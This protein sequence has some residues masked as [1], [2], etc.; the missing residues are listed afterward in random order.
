MFRSPYGLSQFIEKLLRNP[1]KELEPAKDA[2]LASYRA[3]KSG[4]TFTKVK[5]A[6]KAD[7]ALKRYFDLHE[8]EVESW[9]NV[10]GPPGGTLK[11]LRAEMVKLA[12]KDWK[13]IRAQEPASP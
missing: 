3:E 7:Q 11:E 10:I 5:I 9:F 8:P 12:D 2:F 1:V 4:N 13:R 6:V